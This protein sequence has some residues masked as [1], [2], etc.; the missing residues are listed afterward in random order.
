MDLVKKI[1]FI[2]LAY[3]VGIIVV[4]F[5]CTPPK[6]TSQGLTTIEGQK[7][8]LD[9]TYIGNSGNFRVNFLSVND[10]LAINILIDRAAEEEVFT[11]QQMQ[12][13]QQEF[14]RLQDYRAILRKKQR[15]LKTAKE[16]FN[17]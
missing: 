1:D 17:N 2:K 11:T 5:S 12:Q 6:V 4:A 8:I 13:M 10:T 7:Y 3:I 15:R 16:I 14:Q 9:T